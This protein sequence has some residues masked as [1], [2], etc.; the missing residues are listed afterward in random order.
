[1]SA[2][3]HY[4]EFIFFGFQFLLDFNYLNVEVRTSVM[5]DFLNYLMNSFS[6]PA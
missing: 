1:M 6:S 3:C 4:L 5:V 2:I